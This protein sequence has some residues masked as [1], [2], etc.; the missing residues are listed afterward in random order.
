MIRPLPHKPKRIGLHN[1]LDMYLVPTIP[2]ARL[3]R[4][5]R[6]R[7]CVVRARGIAQYRTSGAYFFNIQYTLGGIERG[8]TR[9]LY[10]GRVQHHA[11]S[12]GLGLFHVRFL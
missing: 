6:C 8:Y 10:H 3:F 4:G 5:P 7:H 2:E 12:N 1:M 9:I 11:V